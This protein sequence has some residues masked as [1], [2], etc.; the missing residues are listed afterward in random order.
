MQALF[1]ESDPRRDLP[2]N[3]MAE[4]AMLLPDYV[5]VS[6]DACESVIQSPSRRRCFA[7]REAQVSHQGSK[8]PLAYVQSSVSNH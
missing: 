3:P 5:D 4:V 8:T 7:E 6:L 2:A 1:D